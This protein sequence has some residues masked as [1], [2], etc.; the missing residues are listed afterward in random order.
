MF[1]L[2]KD[3]YSTMICEM[4]YII[5]GD[6]YHDMEYESLFISDAAIKRTF[7]PLS[8]KISSIRFFKHTEINQVIGVIRE[9][10]ETGEA[11]NKI[12]FDLSF[13]RHIT[14][15]AV[16]KELKADTLMQV[17]S[18]CTDKAYRNRSIATQVY[19]M[20]VDDGCVVL[21]DCDQFIP[22]KQLWERLAKDARHYGLAVNIINVHGNFM[23]DENNAIVDFDGSN[24]PHVKIW[25]NFIHDERD[26]ILLVLRK[27]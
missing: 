11:S 9:K 1:N 7:A 14:L 20:L 18:V 6:H 12:V 21:S 4:P 27:L 2:L 22:G 16:P 25:S 8:L 10:K 26:K 24:I 23:R 3:I 5:D 15:K 17:S 19:K 13:K